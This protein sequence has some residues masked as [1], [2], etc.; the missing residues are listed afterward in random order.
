MK[1]VLHLDSFEVRALRDFLH[2]HLGLVK[3]VDHPS[4]LSFAFVLSD[5]LMQLDPYDPLKVEKKEK[6]V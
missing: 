2:L 4:Y 1:V 5:I 6:E 3:D